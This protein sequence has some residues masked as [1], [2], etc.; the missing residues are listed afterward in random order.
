LASTSYD[1]AAPRATLDRGETRRTARG[2]LG[3]IEPAGVLRRGFE[4]PHHVRVPEAQLA[5]QPAD[6][7]GPTDLAQ[8]RPQ[9]RP[10]LVDA[11]HL[12]RQR[13]QVAVGVLGDERLG[14]GSIW[15]STWVP[16]I[17]AWIR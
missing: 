1:H 17:S 9:R 15:M 4:Q 8:E 2:K 3:M 11:A 13:A 14:H 10:L 7:G 6:R 16:P 5:V 12:P